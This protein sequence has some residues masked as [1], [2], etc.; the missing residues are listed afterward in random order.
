MLGTKPRKG[1]LDCQGTAW[2]RVPCRHVL[3]LPSPAEEA[4]AAASMT[5]GA[6]VPD[7]LRWA[8]VG[9][10]PRHLARPGPSA[11]RNMPGGDLHLNPYNT[12]LVMCSGGQDSLPCRLQVVGKP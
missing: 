12:C 3:A 5:G 1:H 8:Q 4:W 9:G 2:G 7:L 11:P 10:S 6:R